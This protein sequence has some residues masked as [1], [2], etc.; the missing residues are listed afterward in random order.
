MSY[1][2][3]HPASEMIG[4][5]RMQHSET[6]YLLPSMCTRASHY[7]L[8]LNYLTSNI[9]TVDTSGLIA[10]ERAVRT[11]LAERATLLCLSRVCS[12]PSFPEKCAAAAAQWGARLHQLGLAPWI[13]HPKKPRCQEALDGMPANNLYRLLSNMFW[14]PKLGGLVS[15]RKGT[16]RTGIEGY[17]VQC[18][19][20]CV[21]CLM[22]VHVVF[23]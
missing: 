13:F 2:R 3:F 17:T 6:A 14:I 16:E 9:T 22:L 12:R 4:L 18:W 19:L 5:G 23:L 11:H 10:Y 7:G 15:E 1:M 21:L 20:V 8:I